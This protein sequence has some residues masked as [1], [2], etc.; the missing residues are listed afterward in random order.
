MLTKE[1][2]KR[3]YIRMM[4]SLRSG[5]SSAYRGRFNCEGV[6][7][8]KKCLFNDEDGECI[9]SYGDGSNS[10]KIIEIVEQ[11]SKEHPVQTNLDK[12][13]EVFGIQ[14][15][16]RYSDLPCPSL[17]YLV[18]KEWCDSRNCSGCR[19]EFWNSEYKAPTVIEA[20]RGDAE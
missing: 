19:K 6:V 14:E 13:K 8:C 18:G 5:Y 16:I 1:E 12:F 11:W 7:D 15:D 9:C 3:D 17:M 20:D 4:D 10:F 2:F